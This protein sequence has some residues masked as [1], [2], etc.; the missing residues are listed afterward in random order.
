MKKLSIIVMLLALV[1]CASLVLVACGEIGTVPVYKGMSVSYS[2]PQMY[3]AKLFA[4]NNNG[5]N[6]NHYG[7][8][9]G[10]YNGKPEADDNNPWGNGD[11]IEDEIGTLEVIGSAQD[12]YFS[13]CYSDIYIVVHIDNPDNYE[14][15]SF[16]LNGKKYS[17]YM[18]E[19]GSDMENLILKVSVGAEAGLKD[20][21]IDAIKYIQGEKIKDVRMDGDKT[22]D[23]KVFTPDRPYAQ[24]TDESVTHNSI[25]LTVQ[26]SDSNALIA[27]SSGKA[28]VVLYDGKNIVENQ[29]ISVGTSNVTFDNLTANKVY[30]YAVFA[31]YHN[32]VTDKNSWNTL[33]K[34]A[35]STDPIVLFDQINVGEHEISYDF[36]WNTAVSGSEI[37][38]LV[39]YSEAGTE[40]QLPLETRCI[41]DLIPNT[42]YTIEAQYNNGDKLDTISL[43]FKT[44]AVPYSYQ[45]SADETHYTITGCD[46]QATNIVIPT[47]I[48]GI[49]VTAIKAQAFAYCPSLISITIPNSVTEIGSEAFNY[50]IGLKTVVI[51]DSVTTIG[52]GAFRSCE[53]LKNVTLGNSIISIGNN[54]FYNCINLTSIVIG[55]KVTTIGVGAFCD[56]RSLTSITIPDSVTSIGDYAFAACNSLTNVTFGNSVTTIGESA[57]YDCNY[58]TTVTIGNGVTT[59]GESAF[60]DCS[61]LTSIIIG[62]KVTTIGDNAFYN[63]PIETATLPT[64]ALNS[65]NKDNLKVVVINGGTTIGDAM[66]QYCSNLTSVTIGNS[67]TTINY[68]AFYECSNLTS[69]TLG[70][71]VTTI[72]NHAFNGCSSL[73]SIAIPNSVATIGDYAF[74]GCPNLTNVTLGNGITTIGDYA[75]SSCSSLTSIVIPDS[76]TTIGTYA[77]KECKNLNSVTLG[78]SLISIGNYALSG[79]SSLTSIVIPDSVTTIGDYAFKECKNLNSVTLGNGIISIGNNAF[80]NCNS[81]TKVNYTG[82]MDQWAQINFGGSYSNPSRY[83]KQLYLN[84]VLVTG[85]VLTTAT[86]ISSY[87]F[88][89]CSSLTSITIPDSVTSIGDYAF[90]NCDSLTSIVIPDS[91]TTIGESAFYSCDSLK[92]V[93][94]GNGV[95]TIGNKAFYNCKNLK[96]V[97]LGNSITAIGEEVFYNCESITQ[98][99]YTGT[100][101][102]WVQINF[103][104]NNSNPLYYAKKLYLNDLLVTDVVLTTATKI[105]AYAFYNC[106]NLTSIALGNSVTTIGDDAFHSCS[107]LTKVNYTGTIDQ[108]AQINF[109]NAYSN[110]LRYANKLY[111]NDVLVTNVVLTTA[112][113][114]SSYAFI[115]CDSLTSIALG[116]NVT[117]IGNYAFSGCDN[118]TSVTFGN[119]VT[120]IGSRAFQNC[121]SLTSIVI[122]DSVTSI[123]DEAFRYCDNLVIYCQATTEPSGWSSKWAYAPDNV[124]WYS[125]SQPTSSGNYWHYVD[126]VVTKW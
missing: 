85:I 86:K 91:V 7:Q 116:N 104:G 119:S 27:E 110:P 64:S 18:F 63:C 36:W 48:G 31:C 44:L 71:S 98:V 126:G 89:S 122:P 19:E 92:S 60:Y 16:T 2:N 23:I 80:Y 35:V 112:T 58:L 33:C 125:E 77:F 94:L 74:N 49:P 10:D 54:A 59:I 55:D 109:G 105:S 78:N 9:K 103:G 114:I 17:N 1:L 90:G 111:L 76:V 8:Y 41:S 73:T 67:V 12:V 6:G 30:Q 100:M 47:D 13:E 3:S 88:Y 83:T 66:F 68:Q 69:V 70:N 75:F 53:N 34:N 26:V 57:F 37:K 4:S 52:D 29:D 93:T 61:N 56:C 97:T 118:L 72:G 79:C 123:G 25:S 11:T 65:I 32:F 14:I 84:D 51:P 107:G 15:V 43:Q 113:K 46:K 115:G 39:L 95:T 22:V 121:T 24:I 106:N 124:Y 62:D 108:W 40:T 101:D 50:C 81:L 28:V 96:N 82:T 117:T 99:N 120:S 5:N 21:T 87:A 45:L 102:Q 38:S 42:N 20:Y